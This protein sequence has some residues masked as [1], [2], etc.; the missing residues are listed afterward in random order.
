MA[1]VLK[2]T[3]KANAVDKDI[4]ELFWRL[5]EGSEASRITAVSEL[6]TKLLQIQQQVDFQIEIQL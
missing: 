4:L 1:H 3:L 5:A 2:K 6:V